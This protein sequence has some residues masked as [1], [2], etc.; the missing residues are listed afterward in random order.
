MNNIKYHA[1][2]ILK[3]KFKRLKNGYFSKR[4][5]MLPTKIEFF[6]MT[7]DVVRCL[8]LGKFWSNNESNLKF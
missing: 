8:W 7:A 2:Q 6:Q 3:Q 1:P 4:R 5:S